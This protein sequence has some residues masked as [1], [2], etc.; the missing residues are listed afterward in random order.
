MNKEP[1]T[2]N[3]NPC[4]HSTRSRYT[5]DRS[6]IIARS[7]PEKKQHDKETP[8]KFPDASEKDSQAKN[9]TKNGE[10]GEKKLA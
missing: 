9:H 3:A 1:F 10:M 4:S 8:A 6:Y 5:A 7:L 2:K